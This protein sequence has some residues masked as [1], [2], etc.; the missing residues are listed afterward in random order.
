[1]RFI[2]PEGAHEIN[3]RGHKMINEIIKVRK[4][5]HFSYKKMVLL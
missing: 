4:K 2:A 3:I 1:M 5:T